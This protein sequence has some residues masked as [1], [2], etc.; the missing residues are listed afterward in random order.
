M[1][2][3]QFKP[4]TGRQRWPRSSSGAFDKVDLLTG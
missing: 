3:D 2:D 4:E 1:G